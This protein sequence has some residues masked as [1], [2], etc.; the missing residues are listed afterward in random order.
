ME[1]LSKIM[2][3][4]EGF[5]L[6][7]P[8]KPLNW[9][10]GLDTD[11][12][13]EVDGFQGLMR[14]EKPYLVIEIHPFSTEQEAIDFIP[15]IW[16]AL[17]RMAVERGNSFV[18]NMTTGDVT[19]ATDPIKAA[20]NLSKIFGISNTEPVHGLVNGDVPIVFPVGKNIRKLKVG[21]PNVTVTS[22]AEIYAPAFV[23]M[24]SQFKGGTAY[25]DERL[26]T[27][28]DLLCGIQQE[29]SL[30]A[31]FLTC[32]IA[33]EVLAIKLP[34]HAIVQE[35]LDELGAKVVGIITD[36]DSHSDEYHA[37]ESLQ[38]E[39]LF[40]KEASLRSSIRRL[41]LDGLSDLP[42]DELNARAK[43]MVLA[44]DVR[45]ALAHDGI[46]PEPELHKAYGIA[47]GVLLD[48][49]KRRLNIA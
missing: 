21:E 14:A 42:D 9:V 18:A 16:D 2:Q 25:N 27:A 7:F 43:E 32:V 22:P 10:A 6:R 35:L 4:E 12:E 15:R 29:N 44:Y 11:Y 45:G 37:L 19:Y 17:A 36:Y 41:V 33:L 3:S 26:H 38:R 8:Y 40:R 47:N 31:K 28:I 46:V 5:K 34:K 13:F 24:L 49:L 1:V 30:R 48:I 23:S 20:E 39:V